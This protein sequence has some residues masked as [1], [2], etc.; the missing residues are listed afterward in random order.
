MK[1]CR[2]PRAFARAGLSILAFQV[3]MPPVSSA[4][5]LH[6][7]QSQLNGVWDFSFEDNFE[8]NDDDEDGGE[9]QE[10]VSVDPSIL[11]DA[12]RKYQQSFDPEKDD[13]LHSC[14]SVGTPNLTRIPFSMEIL[15]LGDRI[16]ILSAL[17]GS[18][19]RIYLSDNGPEPDFPNQYGFS[20]GVWENDTLVVTTT[21]ISEQPF[22]GSEGLPFSGDPE[23]H[24]V[25][26]IHLTDNGGT[27]INDITIVDPKYYVGGAHL[28]IV[29][30]RSEFP[31]I[32]DDCFLA[33]Y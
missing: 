27:L 18:T 23:A 31:I 28:Q 4:Q 8:D 15:D 20:T 19:R 5:Q 17:L 11:T 22:I 24:A 12:A 10:D 16:Y 21:A 3:V 6:P 13:P 30:K 26:R 32:I 9:F 14:R 1:I 2:Y 29:W 7:L 33:T 25:E